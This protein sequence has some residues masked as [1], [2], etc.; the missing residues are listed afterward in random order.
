M[1]C[2]YLQIGNGTFLYPHPSICRLVLNWGMVLTD[3]SG[4]G[5][6]NGIVGSD[7][8]GGTVYGSMNT[9]AAGRQL[10]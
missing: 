9:T 1:A 10:C 8:D 4:P 5:A 2:A 3:L 7:I 6:H